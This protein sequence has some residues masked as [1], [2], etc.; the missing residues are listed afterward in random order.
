MKKRVFFLQKLG[1]KFKAI[2]IEPLFVLSISGSLRK[3]FQK[4]LKFFIKSLGEKNIFGK[5]L[6]RHSV[7]NCLRYFHYQSV[8]FFYILI[9]SILS[10]IR[11]IVPAFFRISEKSIGEKVKIKKYFLFPYILHSIHYGNHLPFPFLAFQ[12][13]KKTLA[14]SFRD[15]D[16]AKK[17]FKKT[18]FD[19]F[20]VLAWTSNY[21]LGYPQK[22]ILA[23]KIDFVKNIKNLLIT[24]CASLPGFN[25]GLANFSFYSEALKRAYSEESFPGNPNAI[26]FSPNNNSEIVFPILLKNN[27][28]GCQFKLINQM[29]SLKA[30]KDRQTMAIIYPI[31]TL[32]NQNHKNKEWQ[33]TPIKNISGFIL[34]QK[35]KKPICIALSSI[36]LIRIR[37]DQLFPFIKKICEQEGIKFLAYIHTDDGRAVGEFFRE[38]N[39]I[40]RSS[41][42][43]GHCFSSL[44]G[45]VPFEKVKNIS[46]TL[47]NW[48]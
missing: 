39:Q 48:I 24:T 37:V 20:R 8:I 16:F 31:A 1:I 5:K 6:Y 19:G 45:F 42:I 2:A 40:G 27:R 25:K 9:G 47:T 41:P 43:W 4:P 23:E 30:L 12:I 13:D 33:Q 11:P 34:A 46:K 29:K 38:N 14:T 26:N 7:L 22:V 17:V 18:S 28:N 44:I 10:K 32:T 3:Y 15:L 36:S 35:R 21:F